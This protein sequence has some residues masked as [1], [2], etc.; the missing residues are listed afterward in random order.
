MFLTYLNLFTY[1]ENKHILNKVYFVPMFCNEK[2]CY[3]FNPAVFCYEIPYRIACCHY[4]VTFFSRDSVFLPLVVSVQ[5]NVK[6]N[7]VI[8]SCPVCSYNNALVR[9]VMEQCSILLFNL[10]LLPW[11]KCYHW[12]RQWNVSHKTTNHISHYSD[13]C[14]QKV[15]L[16]LL[17]TNAMEIAI[18]IRLLTLLIY[19]QILSF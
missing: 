2:S 5:H 6:L 1:F 4:A 7:N 13:A 11:E 18:Y 17:Y 3:Q 15:G 8:T 16:F 12:I 9:A 10:S 14:A 19:P